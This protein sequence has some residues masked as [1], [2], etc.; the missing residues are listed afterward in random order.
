MQ[1]I[2]KKAMDLMKIYKK[3]WVE[4]V[5]Q[6]QKRQKLHE[7]VVKEASMKFAQM[8]KKRGFVKKG[9]N[10]KQREKGIVD[11]LE[12]W[13][14]KDM[15]GAYPDP[16]VR[17]IQ[18]PGHG[19][20]QDWWGD[21]WSYVK[22]VLGENINEKKGDFLSSLFPKSKVDKAIK[23]AKKMSGNM[24]GAVKAI[25]KFFP[26]M[27]RHNDVQDALRKYNE[28]VNEAKDPDIIAKLRDI[29]K[30]KQNKVIKD[31]KSGRKMRVD[32]YS[33]SAIVQVYDAL[34]TSNKNKFS[35]LGLL[36]MQSVAFKFVK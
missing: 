28:S 3:H 23:I 16:W 21:T 36:K 7:T 10:D 29:V 31:P 26:G 2:E 22:K 35:K 1:V 14:N 18:I 9:Q 33:A 17:R 32:G 5:I 4:F 30:N 19:P 11:Y 6:W 20:A 25:E 8:A 34:N 27:S 15:K 24:T 13:A 12:K